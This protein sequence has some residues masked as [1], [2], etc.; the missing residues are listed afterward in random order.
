WE[1]P[2]R[3]TD[4]QPEATGTVGGLL[5]AKR[6]LRRARPPAGPVPPVRGL[7]SAGQHSTITPPP[8]P[9]SPGRSAERFGY[10]LRNKR[11]LGLSPGLDAPEVVDK[12]PPVWDPW[13]DP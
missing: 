6:R 9:P 7:G 1:D 11:R 12:P 8:A 5:W 13:L 2:P 3:P 10:L 4:L